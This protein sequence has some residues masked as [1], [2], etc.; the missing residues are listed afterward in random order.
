MDAAGGDAIAAF[1][2]YEEF[3]DSQV[4]PVDMYYLED[5]ELARQLVEL[6]YRGS[7]EVIKREDF[8]AR[9]LAAEQIRA[10][11]RRAPKPLASKQF[12]SQIA[13]SH[14]LLALSEREEANRNGRMTTIIF[15]RAT[16]SKGQ[17]VSGYIDLAS[18]LQTDDF[19]LYFSRKRKLKPRP[20]DLSFYNWGTQTSRSNS[21]ENYQV[22]YDQGPGLLFK[23]KKDR[24]IVNVDPEL[25]TP[26]DNSTRCVLK[27][28][29][30]LQ[31]V[32]Y[33]HVTRTKT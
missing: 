2:T 24:K 30:Y 13:D 4:A 16:N 3:L 21:T 29:E 25:D 14:F 9:K 8:E 17:E 27:T 15:L 11:Q 31:V 18:R 32:F 20:T 23:N 33:D 7:G 19:D 26:G 28:D 1:D 22:I 5:E 6:G 10:A 12:Q